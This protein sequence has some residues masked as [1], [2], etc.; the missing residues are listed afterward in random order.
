[1]D[2]NRR[3]FENSGE[4]D[5]VDFSLNREMDQIREN[6]RVEREKRRRRAAEIRR[7]E[8][9]KKKK[10]QRLVSMI[11]AW[12][13]VLLVVAG[14]IAAI[15]GIVSLVNKEKEPEVPA[16][17]DMVSGEET[18]LVE[19]FKASKDIVYVK[20]GSNPYA[21]LA[22]DVVLSAAKNLSVTNN[23][24]LHMYAGAYA[25]NTGFGQREKIKNT[26]A[27]MPIYKNGYVW[28]TSSD[29][30]SD[31]SGSY[32]YD[33]HASFI[34]AVCEICLW[35]GDTTFLSV[36][37]KT[38]MDTAK[39]FSSG[40]SV[41]KKLEAA[42]GYYFDK[43]DPNGGG[44]RYNEE[45]GLV[46][47]NTTGNNGKPG[48]NASNIFFTYSF[49]HL[50]CYN[51]L[52]F[53]DAMVSLS[54]LYDMMGDEEKSKTYSD[55]ASKNKAAINVTFY[56]NDSGRY[57]GYIDVNGNKRDYGFTAINLMAVE[58]GVA[59]GKKAEKIM[60]WVKSEAEASTE[61]FPS[62]TTIEA[63]DS[64]WNTYGKYLTSGDA[65]FKSF[66]LNGG[67]SALS[68]YYYIEAND[69][70]GKKALSDCL[71]KTVKD[72][73]DGKISLPAASE[74]SEPDLHYALYAS[75]VIKDT[76]GVSGDGN[77]LTV[78]PNFDRNKNMGIKNISFKRRNYDV[79]FDSGIVYM[80]CDVKAN[81][82]MKIGGF[83]K[84]CKL[85]LTIVEDG[86]ISATEE[87]KAD[88]NGDAVISKTFGDTIYLKLEKTKQSE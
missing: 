8:I 34:K 79:L 65:K 80:F 43:E 29:M 61:P 2:D 55:I 67:Q 71:A 49:G 6:E 27:D 28:S 87:I 48:G 84:D 41:G 81:V 7:Q 78:S 70:L 36:E 62:F 37:D 59:D 35:E 33:T 32:Q 75:E 20:E 11:S 42:A 15:V 24:T 44:I 22:N 46:Y 4:I 40:Q 9:I 64:G 56:D 19:G 68:G 23:G 69:K 45:D 83:E 66:W 13:L 47:I 82:K 50:D 88:K 86:K 53:Y 3:E 5:L 14:I 74:F 77:I 21:K 38:T 18:A 63:N 58:L 12:G 39:D 51:N 72:V 52:M 76:F 10:R 85:T 57:V 54:K 17:G 1:M 73:N 25:W 60:S 31:L 30:K 26:V 16:V